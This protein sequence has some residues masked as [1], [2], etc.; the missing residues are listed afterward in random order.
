MEK[1][2]FARPLP[3][4]YALHDQVLEPAELLRTRPAYLFEENQ[5]RTYA[6][7]RRAGE[8]WGAYRLWRPD[9]EYLWSVWARKHADT[10]LLESLLS[11][12]DVDAWPEVDDR[13][14]WR[15]LAAARGRYSLQRPPREEAFGLPELEYVLAACKLIK[16]RGALSWI[17]ANR[18]LFR[19][20]ADHTSAGLLA[21]LVAL[22]ALK[23]GAPDWQAPHIQGDGLEPLLEELEAE[24]TSH[25][26]M[27][28]STEL[29][30]RLASEARSA[31]LSSGWV[32]RED[33][34]TLLGPG[35]V[36]NGTAQAIAE[37]VEELSF[38]E[39]LL[40]DQTHR[41]ETA[42]LESVLADLIATQKDEA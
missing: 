26:V 42:R 35:P 19:R 1:D 7:A 3:G 25:G 8:P 22:G 18:V 9:V 12:I 16:S 28:W 20:P 17:S 34:L 37:P 24:R 40:A 31:C 13:E 11:V 6:M 39:Q 29:G 36:G 2:V 15:T 27:S 30:Q 38:L 4:V 32:T 14:E 5:V 41:H 33:V 23:Q 10:D 21:I